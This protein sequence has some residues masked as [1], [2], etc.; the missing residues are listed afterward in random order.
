MTD[1]LRH[2]PRLGRHHHERRCCRWV[3][4]DRSCDA[5]PIYH[6]LWPPEQAADGYL[7]PV[8][9]MT[10]AAHIGET[11]SRWL[12]WQ[13]HPLRAPCAMPGAVWLSDLRRCV[14]RADIA[15]AYAGLD[16][17]LTALMGRPVR[18][19]DTRGLT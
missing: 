12:P 18:T 14:W 6:V 8:H 19:V 2:T 3:A 13:V 7:Q 10:C 16:R 17:R 4:P 9:S 1:D 5:E 15:D 11:V